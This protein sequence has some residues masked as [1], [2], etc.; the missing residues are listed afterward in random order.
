MISSANSNNCVGLSFE[1]HS[2]SVFFYMFTAYYRMRQWGEKV[3]YRPKPHLILELLEAHYML[4][5]N[6]YKRGDFIHSPVFYRSYVYSYRREKTGFIQGEYP[7]SARESAQSQCF[8]EQI[9]KGVKLPLFVSVPQGR[10]YETYIVIRWVCSDESSS[11]VNNMKF[12]FQH[13]AISHH[14][15]II[16][17]FN[18]SLNL[19]CYHS[20]TY[21]NW[22]GK[23]PWIINCLFISEFY[24]NFSTMIVYFLLVNLAGCE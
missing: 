9:L 4:Y 5:P 10:Q 17:S 24:L 14:H 21:T 19:S 20:Y 15:A 7:M 11:P 22:N 8:N 2:I 13:R 6:E 18:L 1:L 3:I 16:C 23:I 12:K